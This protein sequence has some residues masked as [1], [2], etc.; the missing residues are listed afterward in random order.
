MDRCLR[1][2]VECLQT[3]EIVFLSPLPGLVAGKGYTAA[4]GCHQTCE[5]FAADA[6]AGERVPQGP[7]LRIPRVRPEHYPRGG[8]PAWLLKYSA[9]SPSMSLEALSPC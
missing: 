5:P 7:V 2:A 9:S 8:H 4:L 1:E 3:S 6:A